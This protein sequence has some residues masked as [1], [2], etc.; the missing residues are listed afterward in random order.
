MLQHTIGLERRAIIH[1]RDDGFVLGVHVYVLGRCLSQM[2]QCTLLKFPR[3]PE[4]GAYGANVERGPMDA[5][6]TFN[7]FPRTGRCYDIR[8][9]IQFQVEVAQQ[10]DKARNDMTLYPRVMPFAVATAEQMQQKFPD[11]P[12]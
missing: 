3:Q 5:L 12:Q 11:L 10:S 6:D 8:Q 1:C 9:H 7:A 2:G 4:C